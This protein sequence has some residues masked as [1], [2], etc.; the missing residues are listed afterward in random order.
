MKRTDLDRRERELKRAK[1]KEE[2]VERGESGE[3]RSVGDYIDDLNG[4]FFQ[5][6]TQIYN[7]QTDE[8]ILE[9]LEDM[10]IDLEERHWESVVRKAV[11]KSGVQQRDKA[12]T[13]LIGL[14]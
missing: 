10:K 1:K 12:V 7:T 3:A 13:E 5:D 9:L 11:K 2:R 4:L 8:R 6:G 14:L